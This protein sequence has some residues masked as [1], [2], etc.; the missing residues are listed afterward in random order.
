VKLEDL[1]NILDAQVLYGE[2][3]L[4]VEIKSISASDL[5]SDVLT[6]VKEGSLLLT[7]LVNQQVVRIAEMAGIMTIC[8]V[9][10]K[11][12]PKETMLALVAGNPSTQFVFDYKKGDENYHFD[13]YA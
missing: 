8:F 7:G 11:V 10:E 5:M 4:S 12:P 1:K 2:D 3:L 6:F 9:H 13:S